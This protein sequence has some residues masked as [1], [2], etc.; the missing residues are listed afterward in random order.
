MFDAFHEAFALHLD[1]MQ[2]PEK[3]RPVLVKAFPRNRTSQ[4]GFDTN[5]DVILFRLLHS[6][7]AS[8]SNS[9]VRQPKG[10]WRKEISKHPVKAGYQLVETGWWEQVA[11]EFQVLAKANQRA[12]ELVNWFHRMMMLYA[13]QMQFFRARGVNDLRFVQRLEDTTTKEYGQELYVRPLQ[14]TLRLELLDKAE[15]KVMET[16]G[17]TVNGS[18][19]D[20]N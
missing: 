16:V 3:D 6:A 15:V 5:F 7:P 13:H 1:S 2:W 10:I 9:A 20:L 4:G 12:D 17:L 11:V 14:Y 19:I 18:S 8:T